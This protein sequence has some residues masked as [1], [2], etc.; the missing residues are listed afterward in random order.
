MALE[1]TH[2]DRVVRDDVVRNPRRWI[3]VGGD[4]Q[5]MTSI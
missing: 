5:S 3:A 2:G 4:T 1:A